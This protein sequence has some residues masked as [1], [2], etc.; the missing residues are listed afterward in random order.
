MNN[1][2]QQI[3]KRDTN[4]L[5]ATTAHDLRSIIAR[6]YGLNLLVEEKVQEHPGKELRKLTALIKSQCQ[7]GLDLTTGLVDTYKAS[8]CSLTALLTRQITLYRYQAENKGIELTTDIPHKDIYVE[9]YP[10]SLI[11]ILD[12]LF[13]NAVKFTPRFGSIK[14][15]LTPVDNE[16]VISFSD[17]G[18][19]IPESFEP[20]LFEKDIQT[21]RP[22]TE[23]ERS[24]GLGLYS[25][26]QM[27]KE[28]NGSIWY[29]SIE[30][31][32]STFYVSLKSRQS[33]TTQMKYEKYLGQCETL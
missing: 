3:N 26:K 1:E 11:R 24:T 31:S 10:V 25:I 6:I 20:L 13:D 22:G 5:I 16:A 29:E 18:I 27:V 4:E 23:N 14:I 12:N 30:N 2:T 15:T 32:G 9:T 21:Q 8:L 33:L 19:G 28:L 17:S 7:Q